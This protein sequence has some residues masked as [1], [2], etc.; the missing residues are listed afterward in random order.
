MNLFLKLFSN[1]DHTF[2]PLFKEASENTVKMSNLLVS[3]VTYT[4]PEKKN[5]I[6]HEVLQLDEKGNHLSSQINHEL[7]KNFLTPF[8]R[9]D[10]HELISAINYVNDYIHGSIKRIQLYKPKEITPAIIKLAELI[11]MSAIE[12]NLAIQEL[13]NKK[14]KTKIKECTIKINSIENHADDVFNNALATLL[15]EENDH[16]EIIKMKDVLSALETATDMCENA[17]S[18]INTILVKNT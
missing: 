16:I 11:Q 10:M 3:I 4:S 13:S 18:V 12:L 8:D 6:Y 2:L 17:A 15:I 7:S 5:E 9:E 1:K 14:N